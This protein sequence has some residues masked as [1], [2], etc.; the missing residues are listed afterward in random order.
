MMKKYLTQL[1]DLL[2]DKIASQHEHQYD[3]IQQLK[4]YQYGKDYCLLTWED[5]GSIVPIGNE[6]YKIVARDRTKKQITL[7]LQESSDA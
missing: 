1:I 4:K 5:V 3:L 7:E 6:K 2:N